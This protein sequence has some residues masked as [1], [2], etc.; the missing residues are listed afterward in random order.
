[1]SLDDAA[2]TAADLV[3]AGIVILFL[4]IALEALFRLIVQRR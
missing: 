3:G 4:L 1:M 2:K